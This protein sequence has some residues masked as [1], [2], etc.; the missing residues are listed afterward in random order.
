MQGDILVVEDEAD[1]QRLIRV[2]LEREGHRVRVASDAAEALRILGGAQLPELVLLDLMLPDLSGTEV[3]RR[4]RAEERTRH[5]PVIMVTAR[6]EEIDRV[7]GLSVGADDY[8]AKPFSVRELCLRVRAI[9]RRTHG[10]NGVSTKV[11]DGLDLGEDG[12]RVLVDGEARQLT[13]LESRL[14]SLL[15]DNQG[16]VFT[17]EALREKVWEPDSDVS[18]Q[19]VDSSVK[20]LRRKLG[21]AGQAIETLRGV[22]YRLSP[23]G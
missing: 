21:D 17:R 7:V 6:G 16:R 13:P 4:L 8:V 3:C 18:L 23:G 11:F 22:G 20:R 10:V 19:A 15:V 1:I 12:G 9:L 2:N 14:L 5:L